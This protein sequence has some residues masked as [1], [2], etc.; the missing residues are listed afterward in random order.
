MKKTKNNLLK[1]VLK[2][3]VF[4]MIF[5]FGYLFY[6]F[7]PMVKIKLMCKKDK[8]S[9]KN[10]KSSCISKKFLYFIKKNVIIIDRF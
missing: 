7:L 1:T 3:A 10:K 4:L 6:L 8:F 5:S 2:R 9:S